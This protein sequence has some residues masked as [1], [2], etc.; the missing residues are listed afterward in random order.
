MALEGTIKWD[1]SH[2]GLMWCIV[3]APCVQEHLEELQGRMAALSA[4]DSQRPASPSAEQARLQD[5][6]KADNAA[7]DVMRKAGAA[8]ASHIEQLEAE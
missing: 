5:Q 2:A 1:T 3:W 4:E 6:I 8:V 7:I